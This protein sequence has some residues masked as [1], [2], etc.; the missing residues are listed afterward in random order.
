MMDAEFQYVS[1]Q[2]RSD[3]PGLLAEFQRSSDREAVRSDA[4]LDR[5]YG[6]HERQRFDFFPTTGPAR[7]TLVYFHAGYWQSRDKASFRFIATPLNDAGFNVALANYPLC[8]DVMLKALV[9]A[10]QPAPAAVA[11]L[12]PGVPMV[13]AGHSA[14]GHLAVELGMR[15]AN[16]AAV[17]GILAISGVFD[18][19]PLLATSLNANLGLDADE[20]E[21]MSPVLRVQ[22][23][24]LPAL[25]AV[26]GDETPEFLAQTKQ[27]TAAWQKAGNQGEELIVEGAH[28]FSVLEALIAPSNELH[29]RL[30]ALA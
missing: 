19:R 15:G 21:R 6:P 3:F 23:S 26:G 27:M 4:L 18:L 13:I 17:C 16:G 24:P 1:G 29:R 22:A 7:A 8:P 20:A 5:V 12:A 28:H 30:A 11:A 2:G 10:A 25:F 14:G 9:L